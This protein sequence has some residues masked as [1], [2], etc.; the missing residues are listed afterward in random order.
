MNFDDIRALT[1]PVLRHR[2]LINFH[3]TSEGVT[4]D[5]IIDQLIEA[6]PVPASGM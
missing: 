5:Q 3:A 4:T 6:V 2:I 1:H